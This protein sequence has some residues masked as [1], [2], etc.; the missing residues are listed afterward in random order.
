MTRTG[1]SGALS[2]RAKVRP[3]VVRDVGSREEIHNVDRVWIGRR[4][5]QLD[6]IL[7]RLQA[8]T[9]DREASPAVSCFEQPERGRENVTLVHRVDDV[10]V[11]RIYVAADQHRIWKRG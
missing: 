4:H 1:K 2:S 9:H 10:R 11:A 3:A 8:G 6:R 7:E 5:D